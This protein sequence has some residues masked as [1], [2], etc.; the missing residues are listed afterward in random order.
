VKVSA[1]FLAITPEVSKEPI[2]QTPKF[3]FLVDD[4]EA[5]LKTSWKRFSRMNLLPRALSKAKS[6][7]RHQKNGPQ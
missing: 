2:T 7:N 5:L 3:G 6:K 4:S 1:Q